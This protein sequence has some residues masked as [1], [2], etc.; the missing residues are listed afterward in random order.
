MNVF[1]F[2][3]VYWVY[4]YSGSIF[5][6]FNAMVKNLLFKNLDYIGDYDDEEFESDD[7]DE[8]DPDYPDFD[9]D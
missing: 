6:I 3:L 4:H 7:E 1:S 9:E 5:S 8:S 2:N